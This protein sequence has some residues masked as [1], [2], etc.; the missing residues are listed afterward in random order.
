[1][2]ARVCVC[3]CVRVCVRCGCLFVCVFVCV[4]VWLFVGLFVCV[5][6]CVCLFVC[7][8]VCL[9]VCLVVCCWLFHIPTLCHSPSSGQ[10]LA[11]LTLVTS[12]SKGSEVSPGTSS[13]TVG[14]LEYKFLDF[15]EQVGWGTG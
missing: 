7:L 6:V 13:K 4:C 3:A 11:L 10:A 14:F 9:F 8:C 12:T 2:G 15:Q 5:C 1:M